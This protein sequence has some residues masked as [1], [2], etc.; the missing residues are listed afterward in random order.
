MFEQYV[1]ELIIAYLL[2][3][4]HTIPNF[5]D[6]PEKIKETHT[7][8]S[9]HLLLNS[10]LDKYRDR[11]NVSDV[12]QRMHLCVNA[13]NFRL[14]TLA[15]IDHK[16]NF[17]ID[18]LNQFFASIGISGISGLVKKVPELEKY[19]SNRFPEG[20]IDRMP[21]KIIFEDLNDLVWRRNMVSHGWPDD[22]LSVDMM[23]ERLEFVKVL[24]QSLYDVL[25]QS[26]LPH[27][28]KYCGHSLS[29]PIAVYNNT[30]ACFKIM[31]G[32]ISD[33]DK[34]ISRSLNGRYCEGKIQELQV[35]GVRKLKVSAPPD[36][37]V[38]CRLNF[39]AK[40]NWDYFL[41]KE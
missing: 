34:M 2:D 5:D 33:G 28:V 23:K 3:L 17:R 30:I 6:M 39:K 37:D 9:A 7:E 41:I 31:S 15:F 21:D 10:Q 20:D 25:R 14:N 12:V 19:I 11:C 13:E 27:I 8:L 24:G 22:T 16:S 32:S 29:K 40:D 4:E 26:V 38:A 18:S 35:D 36:I 1:E